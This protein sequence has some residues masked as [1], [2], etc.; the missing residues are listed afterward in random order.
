MGS[1][2]DAIGRDYTEEDA[3][4]GDGFQ[5]IPVGWYDLLIEK[6]EVK[7]TK[8]GTGSYLNVQFA[9]AGE[10]F[11]NRKLFRRITLDNKN[12]TAKDIGIRELCALG[13]ACGVPQPDDESDLLDKVIQGYV[14]IEQQDGREPDNIV[15]KFRAAG[16]ATEPAKP[17]AAPAAAVAKPAAAAAQTTAAPAAAKPSAVK[18][19]MRKKSVTPTDE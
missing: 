15:K 14:E 7:K 6:A 12:Q 18:P 19:W 9:V 5:P 8:L 3:T 1:I 10:K 2:K 11:K 4:G 16:T 17:K 13:A